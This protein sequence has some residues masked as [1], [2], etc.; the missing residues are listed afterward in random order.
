[1]SRPIVV[2]VDGSPESLAAAH[3]A[4]R[5]GLRRGLPVHLV[6]AW[7]WHPQLPAPLDVGA[8]G[9]AERTVHGVCAL[10]EATHPALVITADMPVGPADA[11][12][13]ACGKNAEMLVLGSRGHSAISGFLLGSV[14]QQ[15]MA[16]AQCPVVMVRADTH[17][18]GEPGPGEVVIGLQDLQH[19]AESVLR[20]AFTA[21]D[22]RGAAVRAVHT[23]DLPSDVRYD[24]ASVRLVDE[25]GTIADREERAL[26]QA[27]RPW[28]RRFPRTPVVQ[29][30]VRGNAVGTLAE[31]ASDAAMVVVGR[32]KRRPVLGMRAGPVTHDV[33]HHVAAPVAVVAHS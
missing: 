10:L 24:S 3:W 18:E 16:R 17:G 29:R 4:A 15:I 33:I 11:A 31:N 7:G 12:L 30:V 20:F 1:M 14:G 13:L 27:I 32:D 9:R 25:D 19:P 22:A 8:K 6:H 26:A 28:Q 5:E 21:A 2:G 23:W